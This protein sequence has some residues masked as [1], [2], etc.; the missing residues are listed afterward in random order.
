MAFPRHTQQWSVTELSGARRLAVSLPWFGMLIGVVLRAYRW[1]V[2]AFIPATSGA[3]VL[4]ALVVG[5]ALLCGLST[6]H[7]ANYTLR[8][9]RGR[10]PALGAFIAVGESA[11]SLALIA[12]GQERYVRAAATFADWPGAAFGILYSRVL[13]VSLYALALAA[14]VIVLRRADLASDG[15]PTG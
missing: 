15:P 1:A 6:L 13:V 10:A 12:V 7:L 8:A 2:L 9:W 5:L 4:A 14:V 11:A 3:L